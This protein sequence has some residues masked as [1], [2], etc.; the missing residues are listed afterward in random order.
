MLV[1]HPYM[2]QCN[3]AGFRDSAT[4]SGNPRHDWDIVTNS[5]S[6]LAIPGWLA[7]MYSTP[8]G[9]TAHSP[10]M[11]ITIKTGINLF[12]VYSMLNLVIIT[13]IASHEIVI[14]THPPFFG[15][16]ISCVLCVRGKAIGTVR[17]SI[18]LSA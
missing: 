10:N 1:P 16:G 17:L 7:T 14:N 2:Y 3:R 13:F 15:S 8:S 5:R 6:V 4:K 12:I 11:E 9:M 18:C